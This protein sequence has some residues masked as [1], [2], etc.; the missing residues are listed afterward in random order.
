MDE[1]EVS[2]TRLVGCTLIDGL[3]DKAIAIAK[4]V[5]DA[6]DGYDGGGGVCSRCCR[7]VI[8]TSLMAA[9]DDISITTS[10]VAQ[11]PL[12]MVVV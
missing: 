1:Q 6:D 5:A 11:A 4:S 8:V 9:G 10:V 7:G 2:K 12:S 3:K